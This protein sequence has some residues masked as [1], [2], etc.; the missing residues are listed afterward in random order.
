MKLLLGKY[1]LHIL[2]INFWMNII[3]ATK[4]NSTLTTKKTDKKIRD[5]KQAKKK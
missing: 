5:Q 3:V 4:L 1:F 2:L